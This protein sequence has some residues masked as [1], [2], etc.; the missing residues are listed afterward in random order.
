MFESPTGNG[1]MRSAENP[2]SDYFLVPVLIE[3]TLCLH[4]PTV[5]Y[6]ILDYYGKV[7]VFPVSR[8]SPT[9]DKSACKNFGVSSAELVSSLLIMLDISALIATTSEF[10]RHRRPFSGEVWA[11]H[12]APSW[13]DHGI[14]PFQIKM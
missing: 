12:V 10:L 14:Y 2:N 4:P 13:L 3:L 6:D 5:I 11:S 1:V 9:P 7:T 8:A